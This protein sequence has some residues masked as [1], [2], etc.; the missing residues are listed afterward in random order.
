MN[1][2]LPQNTGK[3]TLVAATLQFQHS[4]ESQVSLDS[5][6]EIKW[7]IK[8]RKNIL[9]LR[10]PLVGMLLIQACN[11]FPSHRSDFPIE[12]QIQILKKLPKEAPDGIA[13]KLQEYDIFYSLTTSPKRLSKIHYVLETLDFSIAKKVFIVL[14]KKYR[15]KDPYSVIDIEKIRNFSDKIE[16][17]TRDFDYGPAMKLIP[18][19]EEARKDPGDDSKKIVLTFDDD[20]GY[21]AGLPMQLIKHSI[22]HHAVVGGS[23]NEFQDFGVE[24]FPLQ[25]ESQLPRCGKAPLSECD[26]LAGFHGV[27]YPVELVSIPA[28]Q[29][30]KNIA[31]NN[32]ICRLGD[33]FLIS[34]VLAELSV[35]RLLVNNRYT[36]GLL[37]FKYGFEEDALHRTNLTDEAK[38]GHYHQERYMQ[39]SRELAPSGAPKTK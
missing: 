31:Y 2:S 18:A 29:R 10:I 33:D 15:N 1:F 22:E 35:K 6:A 28:V 32:K 9:S 4:Q 16:I 30:I 11:D 12:Q 37:Q 24:I 13:E 17:V 36:Q 25:K 21:P 23:G 26:I 19:V 20:T 38:T 14:P 39:C 5:K 8:M 3:N 27:A 34:Y 7:I